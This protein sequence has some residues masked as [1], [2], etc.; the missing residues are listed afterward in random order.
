MPIDDDFG[1]EVY[2]SQWPDQMSPLDTL[3]LSATIGFEIGHAEVYQEI[4]PKTDQSH[5]KYSSDTG[6]SNFTSRNKESP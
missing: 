3:L 1:E 6:A 2:F 5:L 4:R